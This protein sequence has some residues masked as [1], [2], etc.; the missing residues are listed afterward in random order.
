MISTATRCDRIIALIDDCLADLEDR[1]A[2]GR[3]GSPLTSLAPLPG[4]APSRASR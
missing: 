2:A 4:S 3:P 1:P